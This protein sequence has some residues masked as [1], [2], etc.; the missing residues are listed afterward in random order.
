[1][2]RAGP[3]AQNGWKGKERSQIVVIG[4][5]KLEGPL[6][7]EASL[8]DL[9]KEADPAPTSPFAG[10]TME[11]L[12][13]Q[14][15]PAQCDSMDQVKDLSSQIAGG[16]IRT[17]VPAGK[18]ILYATVKVNGSMEVINGAPG[19]NGPVLNHYNAAAVKK[20]LDRM[21]E[22]IQSRIGPSDRAC[23]IFFYG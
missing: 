9:F 13:V 17:Q 8:F 22:R 16:V 10:R 11:M 23:P 20:Y 1:L 2:D 7:Y 18:Y 6:D 21:S 4:T 14:L 5:H 12:S 19:A 3:L 15:A